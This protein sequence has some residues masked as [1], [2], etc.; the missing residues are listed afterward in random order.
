MLEA[1]DDH[2]DLGLLDPYEYPASDWYLTRFQS[3]FST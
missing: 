1:D 3:A 2:D